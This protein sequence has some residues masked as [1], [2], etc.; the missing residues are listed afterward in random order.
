[1]QFGSRE[2]SVRKLIYGCKW[3]SWRVFGRNYVNRSHA[4][5]R[6]TSIHFVVRAVVA[7]P[8]LPRR[9]YHFLAL[10]KCECPVLNLYRP[11]NRSTL[12]MSRWI[13]IPAESG[14]K[15]LLLGLNY[16]MVAYNR[17][18]LW[19]L[20]A[21]EVAQY[22]SSAAM[23]HRFVNFKLCQISNAFLLWFLWVTAM[24]V[25]KQKAVSAKVN[26]IWI[27]FGFGC[28]L[29][30]PWHS[31]TTEN[32]I[33]ITIVVNWCLD[34][35]LMSGFC[36]KPGRWSLMRSWLAIL[37]QIFANKI[38]QVD[39]SLLIYSSKSVYTPRNLALTSEISF[40]ERVR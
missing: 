18:L 17:K 21:S 31:Y 25:G 6:I 24:I 30:T 4:S 20:I 14:L 23:F 37:K 11:R 3:H 13:P 39:W 16:V 40:L 29:L 10:W 33:C 19:S 27:L 22:V 35:I 8:A 7:F 28:R 26:I 12:F 2:N 36:F 1:M 38:N 5:V 34:S 9:I 15:L 32:K